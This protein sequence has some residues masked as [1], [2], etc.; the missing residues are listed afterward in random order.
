MK[1]SAPAQG[2][3]TEVTGPTLDTD[4]HLTLVGETLK[5][6]NGSNPQTLSVF[7]N[8]VG[9]KKTSVYQNAGGGFVD[10]TD[11]GLALLNSGGYTYMGASD[12]LDLAQTLDIY[13]TQTKYI[14]L[15]HDETNAFLVPGGG[16]QLA[17]ATAANALDAT[18]GYMCIPSSAGAPTGVPANIPTGTIPFQMDSTN[19]KLYA[20][21]GGWKKAQVA[22][23]DVIFG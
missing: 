7:G 1:I 19:K 14:R 22:G 11:G 12:G 17:F 6:A 15:Q 16:G 21:I 10:T 2:F 23:V 20:Y 18:T 4:A 13:S 8:T 5:L 3:N 9:D